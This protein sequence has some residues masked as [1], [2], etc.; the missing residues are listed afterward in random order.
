MQPQ[1]SLVYHNTDKNGN[2]DF[3][4]LHFDA[5]FSETMK[6]VH[7]QVSIHCPLHALWET[8]IEMFTDILWNLF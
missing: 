5:F 6:E 4:E 2:L 7:F 8:E 1:I 3:L